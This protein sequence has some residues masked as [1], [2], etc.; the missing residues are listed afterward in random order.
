GQ[1][2][3]VSSGVRHARAG[4]VVTLD[5]DGQN[6][7]AFIPALLA[8]LAAGAPR[9]GL[10]AGQRVG[11]KATG[12]K[13][14][15]SPTANRRGR[16]RLPRRPAPCWLRA[17]AL[18]AGSLSGAALFGRLSPVAP[19]VGPAR[20]PRYRLCRRGGSAASC[21]HVQLRPVGSAVGRN[22]RSR[23]S[24]VADPPPPSR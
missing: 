11:R 3:A 8:A 21:R 12:F 22:P 10:V 5:G 7:P 9:I 18:S 23:G 19:G 1:S 14:L 15:Q 20:G 17:Q 16:R 4:V 13:K 6:D 2:A 24:L